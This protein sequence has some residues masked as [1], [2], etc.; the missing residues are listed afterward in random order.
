MTVNCIFL[1]A[2]DIKDTLFRVSILAVTFEQISLD[3]SNLAVRIVYCASPLK[4]ST[5]LRGEIDM[6]VKCS[7]LTGN[8]V[9][10][11]LETGVASCYSTQRSKMG[12]RIHTV[13]IIH[14]E[15]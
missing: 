11:L 6:E 7:K 3:D 10:S 2:S 14:K 5:F 12:G 4:Y 8:T 13:S 1:V 9:A 15:W